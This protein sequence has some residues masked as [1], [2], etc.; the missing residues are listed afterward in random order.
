MTLIRIIKLACYYHF[1]APFSI[2]CDNSIGAPQC[3][4][5]IYP[6][7]LRYVTTNHLTI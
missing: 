5:T 1:M 3:S 6:E 4:T 2:Y 7:I